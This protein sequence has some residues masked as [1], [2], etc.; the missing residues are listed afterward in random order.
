MKRKLDNKPAEGPR[1][2]KDVPV[3]KIPPEAG[4]RERQVETG[5]IKMR[6]YG[7]ATKGFMVRGGV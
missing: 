7:A 6:G 2:A 4:G 1:K 5:G 3:N